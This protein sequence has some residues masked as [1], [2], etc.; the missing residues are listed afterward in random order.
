MSLL[1]QSRRVIAFDVSGFGK[2]KP[3]PVSVAPTTENLVIALRQTL[4]AMGID[5]PVDIA[6]NSMGGWMALEAARQGFAR[7][8][9][10]IS[11]AGLWRSPPLRAKYTFFGIRRIAR[12]L[13]GLVN[14]ALSVAWIREIAM[15]MP[16]TTGCR[17]MPAEAA[18]EATSDFVNAADFDRTFANATRFMG[19]QGIQVPVTVAFGTHD[20]LLPQKSRLRDE[21]PPQTHW[22]E[23]VGWGHVPMW[24]DPEGVAKLILSAR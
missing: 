23:P 20:I 21:L 11:P 15:A 5:E 12:L 22:L 9:I 3:L 13:P 16:L 17:R 4:K 6:G 7:S 8:V 14:S 18:I 10:A 1:S 19:G 2:S 24:K